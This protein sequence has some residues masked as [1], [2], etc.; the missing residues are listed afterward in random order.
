[1]SLSLSIGKFPQSKTLKVST[2]HNRAKHVLFVLKKE[3]T[4]SVPIGLKHK[5][6]CSTRVLIDQK[7]IVL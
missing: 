3:D 5:V 4:T 1:M 6:Y 2:L 7:H